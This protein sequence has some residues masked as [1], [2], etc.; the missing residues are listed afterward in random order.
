MAIPD[1]QALM[2]PVL[3]ASEVGEVKISDVVQSLAD[4]FLLSEDERSELLPSGKQTTF[5]NRVHWAKSYLG[6]AG[7]VELTRR[8]HFQITDRG[9]EILAKPPQKIDIKFL[10]QFP[11]FV[12]FREAGNEAESDP[13][14]LAAV[15]AVQ[16][17]GMTPDEII[18]KAQAELD[19]EFSIYSLTS[20]RRLPNSSKDW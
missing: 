12:S 3:R 17:S 13:S 8:A 9:R 5:A 11:E 7:L 19:A 14:A 16:A 4:E 20:L 15:E 18:R 1:F 10:R 6:K 2:L